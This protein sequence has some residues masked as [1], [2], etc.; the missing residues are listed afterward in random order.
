MVFCTVGGWLLH[1][2]AQRADAA[3]LI[4]HGGYSLSRASSTSR[5]LLPTAAASR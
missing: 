1:P 3:S 4:D 2:A 5:S